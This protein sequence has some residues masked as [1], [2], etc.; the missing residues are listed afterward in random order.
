MSWHREDGAPVAPLP[1]SP[2]LALVRAARAVTVG[3][4]IGVVLLLIVTIIGGV[5]NEETIDDAGIALLSRALVLPLMVLAPCIALAEP[6]RLAAER[7]T[8]LRAALVDASTVRAAPPAAERRTLTRGPQPVLLQTGAWCIGLGAVAAGVM[9]AWFVPD[10]SHSPIARV[11]ALVIP[12]ASLAGGLALAIPNRRRGASRRRWDRLWSRASLRWRVSISPVQ[13]AERPWRRLLLALTI[14]PLA[15]GLAAFLAGVWMRRPGRDADRR[16]W[17]SIGE[18]VVDVLVVVGS[19]VLAA[20][21]IL[22]VVVGAGIW[23]VVRSRRDAAAIRTIERGEA[24]PLWHVDAIVIDAGPLERAASALGAVGWVLVAVAG[25]PASMRLLEPVQADVRFDA[26]AWLI[27]PGLAVLVLALV[28]AVRGARRTHDR[29]SL[30]LAAVTRDPVP[31]TSAYRDY[32][33]PDAWQLP[34]WFKGVGLG[35]SR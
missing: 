31:W 13:R 15:I 14:A 32:A 35:D 34:F 30:V 17:D 2:R 21:S 20:G 18:A 7:V 33:R 24:P 5:V 19:G 3:G 10:D 16:T 12:L 6:L 8:L 11:L 1:L 29:R 26:L 27:A 22:I 28:V 23:L 4:A 9:G 25:A